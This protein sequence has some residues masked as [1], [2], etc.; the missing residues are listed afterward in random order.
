MFVGERIDYL[1]NKEQKIIQAKDVFSFS[2]DAVLLASFAY[3]PI[4]KGK[5]LD[6]CS[7]NGVIPILL[8]RRTNAAIYGV[9]IQERL[10]DMAKRS[11]ELNGLQPQIQMVCADLND[12]P[13]HVKELSYDVITCNPPYFEVFQ[14]TEQHHNP[15]YN[16]ARHEI[17]CTLEDVIRISSRL[18]KEKGKLALVHRPERLTDIIILMKKYKIEPKRMQLVHPKKDKAANMVLMEGTKAAQPGITCLEPIIVYG[19]NNIYTEEFERIY[20]E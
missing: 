9:E 4:Q 12:L 13:L 14:K 18:M 7:G 2:I 15:Y 1:P 5:I 19:E 3:V 6:L 17:F 8:S 20:Y 11:I 16:I 10:F